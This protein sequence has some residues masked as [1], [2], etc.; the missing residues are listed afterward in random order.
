VDF[1]RTG[2]LTL[3]LLAVSAPAWAEPTA[4]DRETAR[5]LLDEGDKLAATKDME[6]AL[7]RYKRAHEIMNVPSTGVEVVKALT[8]LRRLV[9]ARDLALAVGRMPVGPSEGQAFKSARAEAAVLAESLRDQIPTLLI[10]PDEPKTGLL[11]TIDG[12]TVPTA[13]LGSPR[14]I[15]PGTHELVVTA[16]GYDTWKTIV[17]LKDR[18]R[19]TLAVKLVKVAGVEPGTPAPAQAQ[20]PNESLVPRRSSKT[21]VYI[22]FGVGG[23]GLA[24]GT[25]TGLMSLSKVSS[26]KSSCVSDVCPSSTRSDRDSA[27]TMA[28]V[29]NISFGVGLVAAGVGTYLYFRS[30]DEPATAKRG[31]RPLFAATPTSGFAGVEGNLP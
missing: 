15:D 13:A 20:K 24:L 14:A 11:V 30:P 18:E 4:A 6:G 29:S 1:R 5:Q 27:S 7:A 12:N 17:E 25:V 3:F 26:V 21:P 16:A 19:K 9:E 31:V 8:A 2:I 22:A 23:A 10:D 28:W